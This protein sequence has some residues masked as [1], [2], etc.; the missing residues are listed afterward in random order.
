MNRYYIIVP[1]ILLA[2]FGFL[3]AQF[4]SE[5]KAK[6]A[7]R[8]AQIQAAKDEDARKRHEADEKARLDSERRER[9]RQEEEA[10][11]AK[12]KKDKYEAEIQK[13]RDEIA[14]YTGQVNDEGKQSAKLEQDLANL[15]AT[16]EKENRESFDLNKQVERAQID[17]RNAEFE[18]QR[19]TDM[20]VH[21]A[22]E[23]SMARMP[24]V[25]ATAGDQK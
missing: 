19:L 7:Q 3:Y 15:R 13:I 11:K 21:R 5:M 22:S 1:I 2:G 18:I 24:A 16:K 4:H 17:R 9:E 20:I 25:A 10:K 6:E 23:S 14:H 12:D 8:Q